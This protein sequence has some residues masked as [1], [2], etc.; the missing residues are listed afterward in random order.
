MPIVLL[1]IAKK[2][3]CFEIQR[4]P[5]RP[6]RPPRPPRPLPPFPPRPPGPFG[7]D[8]SSQVGFTLSSSHFGLP[9]VRLQGGPKLFRLRA[10]PSPHTGC[11]AGVEPLHIGSL[12]S[13]QGLGLFGWLP[14]E[15]TGVFPSAHCG[16]APF[17]SGFC[18]RE[19]SAQAGLVPSEQAAFV[20]L[21]RPPP[22]PGFSILNEKGLFC[23]HSPHRYFQVE[24]SLLPFFPQKQNRSLSSWH[25]SAGG[26]VMIVFS[27]STTSVQASLSSSFTLNQETSFPPFSRCSC[28][29]SEGFSLRPC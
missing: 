16:G 26:P 23:R 17:S 13:W 10:D 14:S 9:C 11:F 28:D 25:W 4:V 6:P 5:S 2:K 21:A 19:P 12:S 20:S 24:V 29:L 27:A 15:H 18:G 8:P 7:I 3:S 1:H 22:R